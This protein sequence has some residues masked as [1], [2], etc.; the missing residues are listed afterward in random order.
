MAIHHSIKYKGYC[1]IFVGAL[2]FIGLFATLNV[3]FA[4]KENSNYDIWLMRH[5]MAKKTHAK[6][7]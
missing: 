5:I 4:L 3:F 7:Y 1:S 6:L 2:G